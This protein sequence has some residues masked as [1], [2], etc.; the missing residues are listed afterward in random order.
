MR[1]ELAPRGNRFWRLDLLGLD[2]AL[3]AASGAA[4]YL[5]SARVNTFAGSVLWPA[6]FAVIVIGLSYLRGTYRRRVRLDLLDDLR[7][8]GSAVAVATSVVVTL[9][10]LVEHAPASATAHS[11]RL[12]VFAAACIGAGRVALDL[13][14]LNA[15]RLGRTFVPTLIVGAGHVGRTTAKR[16]LE[17]PELGLRPIGFLDNEPREG[18]DGSD[19]LPVLGASWDFDRIATEHGVGQVIVTFSTAPSEVLLRIVRR[20]EELGIGVALVPRLFEKVTRRLTIDHLGGL[21]LVTSHPSNPKGWQIEVK[22]ALDRIVALL[23]LCLLAPV[24]LACG[25]A[26]W[27]SHGRPILFRQRRV[28]RDGRLFEMLKF[29]SICSNGG[30]LPSFSDLPDDVAPGGVNGHDHLT[31]VGA[32][33]RDTSLDELPQFINVLKGE[34][35]IVGPR[36]ERP[37][38]VELFE[39]RVYRYGDRHRVKSGITGWAQVNGLRGK[40]SLSDRVEWDNYYIENRSVWF[41]LKILGLTL[42]S[43]CGFPAPAKSTLVPLEY[44]RGHSNGANK[45][46]PG[47]GLDRRQVATGVGDHVGEDLVESPLGRPADG[48]A[49]LLEQGDAVKHVLDPLPVDLIV[50]DEL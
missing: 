39:S 22:Y 36:P 47:T 49:D 48:R 37:E 50:R 9:R 29:R 6:L 32:F 12:G 24:F 35:S 16:L 15:R 33:L 2:L 28:G 7:A 5:S 46:S 11:I 40:T 27:L 44:E 3:L 41:D 26:V 38:Y 45:L 18:I 31:R 17:H 43:L 13:W 25:L 4:A 19:R 20:C 34:M 30:L 8:T 21:P 1:H 10:V 42:L 14:Q 23:L